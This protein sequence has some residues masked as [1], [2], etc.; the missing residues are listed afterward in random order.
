MCI[1]KGIVFVQEIEQLCRNKEEVLA[2][3]G[4]SFLCRVMETFLV[5]KETDLMQYI[6]LTTPFLSILAESHI[7]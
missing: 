6:N 3:N 2:L 7:K 1:K 5:R 4:N